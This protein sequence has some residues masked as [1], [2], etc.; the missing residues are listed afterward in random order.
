MPVSVGRCWNIGGRN[1]YREADGWG[2]ITGV[3]KFTEFPPL[4]DDVLPFLGAFRALAF[5]LGRFAINSGL[6]QTINCADA[7]KSEL[8]LRL[9]RTTAVHVPLGSYDWPLQTLELQKLQRLPGFHETVHGVL[10][11]LSVGQLGRL[12]PLSVLPRQ[13]TA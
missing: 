13:G 7:S 5:R 12:V 8:T 11:H 3:P 4:Y 1:S 10:V 9:R 6:I 2:R